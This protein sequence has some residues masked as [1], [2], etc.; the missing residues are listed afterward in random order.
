MD[1]KIKL[2]AKY[3]N[4]I[5]TIESL[6]SSWYIEFSGVTWKVFEY[7]EFGGNPQFVGVYPSFNIAYK[8]AISLT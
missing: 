2:I 8:K 3:C 6:L 4:G 5:L 1:K 7:P